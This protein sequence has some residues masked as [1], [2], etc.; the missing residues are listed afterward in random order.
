MSL[1]RVGRF[2]GR[3][4]ARVISD[5]GE[6][7]AGVAESAR[8]FRV[9]FNH[10]VRFNR[11]HANGPLVLCGDDGVVGIERFQVLLHHALRRLGLA[12][13]SNSSFNPHLTIVYG[14]DRAIE[15]QDVEPVTW[16]ATD[17]VLIDSLTGLTRHDTL[18]RWRLRG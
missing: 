11:H 17:F 10:V 3:V 4:P 1:C 6:I 8:P 14:S 7:A 18:G 2:T 12:R 5:A 15:E 9:Q 16:T 13:R